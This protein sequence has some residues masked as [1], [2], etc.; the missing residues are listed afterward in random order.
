MLNEKM[1]KK[2][3]M[4]LSSTSVASLG[5]ASF[6]YSTNVL[7]DNSLS[8]ATSDEPVCYIK[9]QENIFYSTISKACEIAKQMD[10]GQEIFVIAPST[11]K[12]YELSDESGVITLGKDDSLIFPY[13]GETYNTKSNGTS[14][15][16]YTVEL[17]ANNSLIL[18][19]NS[20]LIV[21]GITG[22][23]GQVQGGSTGSYVQ[24]LLDDGSSIINNGVLEVYG[25]I[26]T[27]GDSN[28]EPVIYQKKDSF[29]SF[30]LVIRDFPGGTNAFKQLLDKTALF[31]REY[32]FPNIK[33]KM[34]FDYGSTLFGDATL[35][36]SNSFF[37][38]GGNIISYDSSGLLNMDSS[39]S[40]ITWDYT[41]KVNSI[42]ET[43]NVIDFRSDGSISFGSIKLTMKVA[44]FLPATVD[45]SDYYFPIIDLFN[46]YISGSF[47][48]NSK[49]KFLPGS[50]IYID[51]NSAINLNADT[52]IYRLNDDQELQGYSTKVKEAYL[53]NSG[54]ININ[55]GFNGYIR[56]GENMN[57]A[58]SITTTSSI[59]DLDENNEYSLGVK[60][61]PYNF[62]TLAAIS[63]DGTP[64]SFSEE[65]P[66]SADSFYAAY[67][68]NDYKYW[69]P[70]DSVTLNFNELGETQTGGVGVY[71][72]SIFNITVRKPT[73]DT[74]D[75]NSPSFLKLVP[76]DSFK[77]SNVTNVTKIIYNN[78]EYLKENF[79]SELYQE[80][81]IITSDMTVDLYNTMVENCKPIDNIRIDVV[82]QE[83]SNNIELPGTGGQLKFKAILTPSAD[84]YYRDLK[85]ECSTKN[86]IK[87][88]EAEVESMSEISLEAIIN[89]PEAGRDIEVGVKLTLYDEYSKTV[90]ESNEITVEV[91]GGCFAKGSDILVPGFMTKK[92]EELSLGD[93]VLTFN[94]FSG[95]FKK[96]RIAYY[97]HQYNKS[98]AKISLTFDD[99]K[100][101]ELIT[102]HCLLNYDTR[103]FDLINEDNAHSFV[104][105]K[106]LYYDML[107][108]KFCAGKLVH[109]EI[110]HE[111]TESYTIV[112]EHS[113]THFLG[114]FMAMTDG[115]E[116]FY[117]YLSLNDSFAFDKKELQ[118]DIINYGLYTYH[119]FADY[120]SKYE[121]RAFQ[122]PYLKI[123]VGKNMLTKEKIISYINMYLRNGISLR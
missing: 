120:M 106:Y 45:T 77:F 12:T 42:G 26:N 19:G 111:I 16:A 54:I 17:K 41:T 7:I 53:Y 1:A 90:K 97:E 10:G 104:G 100:K 75:V 105:N 88:Y 95:R 28:N 108:R 9:G 123:S 11:V 46:F 67:I 8:E 87:D 47:N 102:A 13:S 76:G 112:T 55:A 113:L 69:Y 2:S 74:Y 52:I 57:G 32:D 4:L 122:I 84:I 116:G 91:Q 29:T 58:S 38:T 27:N 36:M 50:S 65:S 20:K 5:F 51:K 22:G 109:V 64:E 40:E 70:S 118:N 94:Q 23:S 33:A 24:M 107:K 30:P 93:Y 82:D 101:I 63:T 119:E 121:F 61:G 115:I 73:G 31:F 103:K 25:F 78:K 60:T 92:I 114:N 62:P 14:K 49:V 34:H 56:P 68:S 18:E 37:D 35:Y 80:S 21:G 79:E 59:G 15:L 39:D 89:F 83:K 86:W 110:V 3:L 66:L 99:N 72:N 48:V 71:N 44:G 81:F 98:F 6:L 85:W 43:R 96:E 117:N